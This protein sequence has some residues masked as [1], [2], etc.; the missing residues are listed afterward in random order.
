MG[1]GAGLLVLSMAGFAL[2]DAMAKQVAGRFGAFEIAWLRYLALLATALPWALLQPAHAKSG[3][4]G[5]QFARAVALVGS[6]VLFLYGLKALPVA[7][8]TA[9][10]FASPL[11][12]TL[13][14][15][16]VLREVVSPARWVPVL[17]GF[18]G[19]LVVMRPGAAGLGS[20]AVFPLASS[21]AW[22]C[23]VIL[24]RRLASIDSVPTTMLY[25]AL[26]GSL[27]LS[28]LALPGMDLGAAWREAPLL[29]A[30]AGAWCAAQWLVIAAYRLAHPSR[31]APFAYSQLVWAAV[32]GFAVFGHVPDGF[33]LAGMGI[34]LASGLWAAWQSR[35]AA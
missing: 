4:P 21:A 33:S 32:L 35:A 12:V 20:A 9:M 5:L 1:H 15:A 34:I 29:A 16:L 14:A 17:L 13:L 11:F 25:S 24:T 28:A 22:A 26:F 3:H 8:A 19:V 10:V 7:E 23:A 31:I 2:S 30:M 6:A 18:A 27:G